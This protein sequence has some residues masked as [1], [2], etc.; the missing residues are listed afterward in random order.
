MEKFEKY[1]QLGMVAA[2]TA[3]KKTLSLYSQGMNPQQVGDMLDEIDQQLGIKN[4]ELELLK[5][6]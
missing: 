1:F 2:L 5:R 6:A 4:A 3:I